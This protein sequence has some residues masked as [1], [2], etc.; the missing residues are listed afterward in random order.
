MRRLHLVE[1]EDLEGLP[2]SIRNAMT[3]YL[4]FV[5]RLVPLYAAAVPVLRNLLA[6]TGES[7]ILDLASGGGGPIVHLRPQVAAAV[8]RPVRLTLTD[9][10][11]NRPAFEAAAAAG[12]GLVDFVAERVDARAVPP[13]LR[14]VRTLFTALHHF[15]P[16]DAR[17]VLDDAAS[18]GAPI[19]V[20]EVTE[21]S[22]QAVASM[23]LVPL[24]ILLVT[25]FIRPFRWSR[26]LWTYL[27]PVVPLACLWDGIVSCLR[28]YRPGELLDLA[29][30]AGGPTYAWEAGT[31]HSAPGARVTYLSGRPA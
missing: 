27:V 30:G 4:R 18:R 14:G 2:A 31:L 9:W 19:A 26:L 22:P 8:G 28:T 3:D 7:R 13:H 10:H 17:A 16:E 6:S 11:P 20:F 25:P 1:V 29:Q 15:R 21:R 23:L 24:S 12:D 5:T